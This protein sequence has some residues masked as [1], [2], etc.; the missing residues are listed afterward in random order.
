M[1]GFFNMTTP[2]EYAN[3][4]EHIT[5]SEVPNT[6]AGFEQCRKLIT[7]N[8]GTI[9][10]SANNERDYF[11]YWRFDGEQHSVNFSVHDGN[12]IEITKAN[13]S[14]RVEKSA[15][16]LKKYAEICCILGSCIK[17]GQVVQYKP[18]RAS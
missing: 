18:Y 16:Y 1:Y 10:L 11:A 6:A 5:V 9:F 12:F 4:A 13:N 15:R 3:L 8:G 14:G 17:Y 2:E 7:M